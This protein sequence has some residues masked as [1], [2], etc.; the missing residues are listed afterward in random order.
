M[1]VVG[2]QSHGAGT[3]ASGNLTNMTLPGAMLTSP[4]VPDLSALNQMMILTSQQMA[5]VNA[6]FAAQAAASPL[7]QTC[8][9]IDSIEISD[10]IGG[11][12]LCTKFSGPG[13]FSQ[14]LWQQESMRTQTV[15]TG[16]LCQKSQMGALQAQ[17]NCVQQKQTMLLKQIGSLQD[18]FVKN[19][20]KMQQD[21]Q[22]LDA[23]IVDRTAQQE[24]VRN[25]LDGAQGSPGMISLQ[26]EM[27]KAVEEDLPSKVTSFELALKKIENDKKNLEQ[28]V[29]SQKMGLV[30]Q[31]F[32][33][34][35]SAGISAGTPFRCTPNGP[36]VSAR[37]YVLCRYE[38]NR[39][40]G[41][42]G[43][44]E[45]DPLLAAQAK[46][47]RNALED[48]LNTI[49]ND[50]PRGIGQNQNSAEA[51]VQEANR[52]VRIQ[53]LSDLDRYY[54][55]ALARYNGR[56]LNIRGFV[57]ET[58]KRC[59]SSA[60][61]VVEAKRTKPSSDIGTMINTI[62]TQEAEAK[63]AM[64]QFIEKNA[65]LYEKGIRALTG[66]SMPLSGVD[67]CKNA[68]PQIRIRCIQDEQKNLEGLLTGRV[69][70][71]RMNIF[72]KGTNTATYIPIQCMG[73][74]GCVRVLNNVEH[75][76]ELE[77]KRVE[78][79]KK[80]YILA[81]KQQVQSFVRAMA[82]QFSQQSADIQNSLQSLNARLGA[83]GV[84][85][86]K[87]EP[88]PSEES[89]ESD[90]LPRPPKNIFGLIGSQMNPP[91][92]KL[93]GDAISD[94]MKELSE[95]SKDLEQ[96]LGEA[97]AYAQKLKSV[98]LECKKNVKKALVEKL[99]KDIEKANECATTKRFCD[100]IEKTELDDLVQSVSDL[101]LSGDSSSDEELD[102][103]GSLEAGMSACS[104]TR[105]DQQDLKDEYDE[106]NDKV[107]A[108]RGAL[109]LSEEE[110]TKKAR[111]YCE[112][113]YSFEL[114]KEKL[115][116]ELRD[117][118]RDR[119]REDTQGVSTLGC[120]GITQRISKDVDVLKNMDSS[121]SSSAITPE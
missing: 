21:V 16:A 62:Q 73:L 29:F 64:N 107:K 90:G 67:V 97:Q 80:D 18:A 60:N 50:A 5:T 91:M 84:A 115:E 71:S 120:S 36:S 86:L 79:F 110:K 113:S 59:Y 114:C 2:S 65:Q 83:L 99:E 61:Q 92:V 43:V 70:Q 108:M 117:A 49:F 39:T 75:N 26:D 121:G 9:S 100:R 85:G 105:S 38:Q 106:L 101:G 20:Q 116:R 37:E 12:D 53:S 51:A 111:S 28:T 57:Q 118:Q 3:S 95:K 102:I 81:A 98:P 17:M 45:Q 46:S 34:S 78:T 47:E 42:R 72:V 24:D 93:D 109:S 104:K 63:T 41:N 66:N 11:K 35:S 89:E 69:Q 48:L 56:G 10:E 55:D 13:G 87:L 76:L 31:C 14:E 7:S 58:V 52:G 23:S 82:S 96:K 74:N 8:P 103:S 25:K 4:Q 6:C 40:L 22:K 15:V 27:Q 94:S 44:I 54:G 33:Q 119:D 19:I 112:A 32:N 88:Y 68:A 30:S 77:K 1:I